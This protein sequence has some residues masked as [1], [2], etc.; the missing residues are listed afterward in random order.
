MA[1]SGVNPSDALEAARKVELGAKKL[2]EGVNVKF[3]YNLIYR[4][5][6]HKC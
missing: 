5:L 6:D 3:Y 2:S 4:L 1:E